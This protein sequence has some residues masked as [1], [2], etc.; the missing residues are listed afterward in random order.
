M[1]V[2]FSDLPHRITKPNEV[3]RQST[4]YNDIAIFEFWN[5]K[6]FTMNGSNSSGIDT[7]T[8]KSYF[9]YIQ[10]ITR[11]IDEQKPKRVLII[12]AAWFTLPQDIATRDY[13]EQVDVCDIDGALDVIAERHFLG[14]SLHPK[15]QFYKQSAR[16]F[17]REKILLWE[18]YDMIFIDAYNGKISIPS[19]LLTKEFFD[20]IVRISRGTISM[21][22]IIDSAWQSNFAKKLSNTLAASLWDVYI[23]SK[24]DESISDFGNFLVLNT[25]ESWYMPIVTYPSYDLYTDNM[26]TLERDKYN[27]FYTAGLN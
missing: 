2:L 17:V 23:Q 25:E 20:S 5:R 18:Q 6:L 22:L 3:Y 26:N 27:L 16:Y 14:Q 11:L 8:W 4:Q 12:G 15:I 21:N 7:T 1:V 10:D 19:E 13:I 24:E 9:W